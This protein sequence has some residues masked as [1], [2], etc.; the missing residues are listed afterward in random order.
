MMILPVS[1]EITALG[2]GH[3]FVYKIDLSQRQQVYAVADK[4]KK[5]VRQSYRDGVSIVVTR[6]R[7]AT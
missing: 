2:K 1:S 3:V 5:E 6:C 4:V 7:W